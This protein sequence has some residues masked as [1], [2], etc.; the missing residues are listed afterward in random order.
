MRH[1]GGAWTLTAEVGLLVVTVLRMIVQRSTAAAAC[2]LVSVVLSACADDEPGARA[3]PPASPQ[4][5]ASASA[6]GSPTP[7]A[8]AVPSAAQAGT[9]QGAAEF[10]RFF[11]SEVAVGFQ[12]QSP[13][14]VSQLSLPACETCQRYV[15]SIAE[16][17]HNDWRVEG[18][19][20]RLLFA[21]APSAHPS[22]TSVIDVA[23]DFE[24]AVYYDASGEKIHEAPAVQGVEE[25]VRLQRHD[26]SWVV[27]EITTVRGS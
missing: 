22:G 7:A 25:T 18:G 14:R 24:P 13:D 17:K 5:S 11:Y 2:L 1:P 10:A 26:E 27:E 21:E 12:T 15:A 23:W 8:V 9:P 3:L 19:D 6:G 16:A 4:A 20:F